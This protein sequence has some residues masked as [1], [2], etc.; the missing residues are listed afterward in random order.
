M[1]E[2]GSCIIADLMK[3]REN[4]IIEG[5]PG[6]VYHSFY[7]NGPNDITDITRVVLHSIEGIKLRGLGN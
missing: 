3:G 5:W 7:L 1:N 6:T 2:R 4:G